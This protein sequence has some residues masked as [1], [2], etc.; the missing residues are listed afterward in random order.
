MPTTARFI[1]VLNDITKLISYVQ[2]VS[3]KLKLKTLHEKDCMVF[4]LRFLKEK[5]IGYDRE[6]LLFMF[7]QVPGRAITTMLD[8]LQDC[9][10]QRHYISEANLIATSK[11]PLK[12]PPTEVSATRVLEPL[13]RCR[14]CTL[15]PPCK[16]I[17]EDS[18]LALA[19]K[20]RSELPSRIHSATICVEYARYGR[21]SAFNNLGRC[22]YDHP[23]KL[24]KVVGNP[25]RCGQCTLIW[26]CYHCDY[27]V[28][29]QQ[30]EA[31]LVDLKG[32]LRRLKAAV[33]PDP[34]ISLS[35][36]MV[37]EI[38]SRK[39]TFKFSLLFI[40]VCQSTI[41]VKNCASM[42]YY[43]DIMI[44]VFMILLVV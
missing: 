39:Y 42:F 34:P 33:A 10:L 1:F 29:R 6:G 40:Y 36:Y 43:C 7:K 17:P 23:K 28:N 41:W 38:W 22:W 4:I 19:K 35:Y 44:V 30:L 12:V 31:L 32:R 3:L 9:F 2:T 15:Y 18:F 37:S 21:C 20:R 5:N 8:L 26:P 14:I 27:V 25:R 11:I 16:H 13:P 24:Y